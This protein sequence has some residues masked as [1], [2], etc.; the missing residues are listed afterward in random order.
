M[1]RVRYSVAASL[2]GFIAG[3]NGE[4][5]W[6]VIDPDIDFAALT[7]E[8]DTMLV[9][10]RTFERSPTGGAMPG[11]ATYVFS[12]TLRSA[13]YPGVT[14]V[15]ENAAA[16][17][18]GL[19]QASGRDIWLFGGGSLFASLLEAGLV[20]TV[21]LAVIPVLLGAGTPLMPDKTRVKL[22]LMDQSVLPK[23]GTLLLKYDVFGEKASRTKR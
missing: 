18:A 5:D 21:E 16:L 7:S 3:P 22:K 13:D 10:R 14:V 2:D 15:S 8:F 11:M 20:D 23:T 6:I 1:K 9:G 4:D 12:R 17:V 19:R